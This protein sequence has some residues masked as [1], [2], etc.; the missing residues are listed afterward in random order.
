M[1]SGAGR[2]TKPSD[3][4]I[5]EMV[6]PLTLGPVQARGERGD[7]RVVVR[8]KGRVRVE[9]CIL[10]SRDETRW[11][12]SLCCLRNGCRVEVEQLYIQILYMFV[13]N[14]KG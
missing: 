7:A 1:G 6:A 11:F 3:S 14:A 5:R 4:L 8:R 13:S 10:V 2:A 12:F 9:K